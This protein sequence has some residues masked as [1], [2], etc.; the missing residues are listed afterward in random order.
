MCKAKYNLKLIDDNAHAL[1]NLV[2]AELTII[3]T[4]NP[5]AYKY[6]TLQQAEHTVR[7]LAKQVSTRITAEKTFSLLGQFIAWLGL[8]RYETKALNDRLIERVITEF[9]KQWVKFQPLSQIMP[10]D[11]LEHSVRA[12]VL[13]GHSS[14]K[15]VTSS[16]A[17]APTASNDFPIIDN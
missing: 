1:A 13:N 4:A 11:T 9:K 14:F 12:A 8:A 6:Y 15:I 16:S 3:W 5:E 10:L 7:L 2:V 17:Y